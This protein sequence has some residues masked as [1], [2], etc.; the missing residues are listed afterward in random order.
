MPIANY[1]VAPW[2]AVAALLVVSPAAR[3]QAETLSPVER[4]VVRAVDARGG[5]ALDLLE[6]LV[7]INSGTMHFAGVRAV[8]DV[9]RAQLD[10]LGFRTR[11]VD[12]AAFDRAGH[13]V[14]GQPGPGP[15]RLLIGHLG[16]VVPATSAC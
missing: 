5:D 4:R 16:T 3:G 9:L 7:N 13:L 2:A 14:G 12:G 10:S 11:W 6:R 1:A 8:G 15:R